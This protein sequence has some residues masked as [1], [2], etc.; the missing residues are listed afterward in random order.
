MSNSVN[1]VILVGRLGRDPELRNSNDE[2]VFVDFSIATSSSWFD[3]NNNI[4]KENVQWHNCIVF[5]Q[6]VVEK[7]K[8]LHK[9]DLIYLEGSLQTRTINSADSANAKPIQKTQ[10]VVKIIN[11]LTKSEDKKYNNDDINSNHIEDDS[12]DIPF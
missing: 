7:S 10:I 11:L 4:W 8:K 5:D 9:G 2:R 1:K 12:S 3:K 6:N